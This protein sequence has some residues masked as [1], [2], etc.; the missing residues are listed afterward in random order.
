MGKEGSVSV[1]KQ[2]EQVTMPLHDFIAQIAAEATPR[3]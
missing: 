2:N 1:R 3:T